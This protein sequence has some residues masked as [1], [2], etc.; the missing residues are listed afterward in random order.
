MNKTETTSSRKRRMVTTRRKSV[1]PPFLGGSL[2][3]ALLL[4]TVQ[5]FSIRS[6]RAHFNGQ[7][8]LHS[9]IER[10]DATSSQ[11]TMTQRDKTSMRA[12]L[13]KTSLPYLNYDIDFGTNESVG[14]NEKETR[15]F[16][17]I[18]D[19]P[20]RVESPSVEESWE[21]LND[22][23]DS[24]S[25]GFS[26]GWS[27]YVPKGVSASFFSTGTSKQST[28]LVLTP[29]RKNIRLG[30]AASAEFLR[31][32][33]QIN[34]KWIDE[35]ILE[36]GGVVFR[37]FG[38]AEYSKD[39]Y[40]NNNK[41]AAIGKEIIRA[42]SS[43]NNKSEGIRKGFDYYMVSNE[44]SRALPLS[45]IGN[46]IDLSNTKG[47]EPLRLSE[48]S[49]Q[50]RVTDWRKIHDDLPAKLRR[51]LEDKNLLYK[52]THVEKIMPPKSAIPFRM[53][54]S[55][56]LNGND[57]TENALPRMPSSWFRLFGS[58]NKKVLQTA[59]QQFINK[60][61][62]RVE[63]S[64][65]ECEAFRRHPQTNEKIWFGLAHRFHWTS[66]PAE[67]LSEFKRNKNP[68]AL[69]RA[70]RE[71]SIGIWKRLRWRNQPFPTSRRQNQELEATT[72]AFGDGIPI[73]WWE[74]HQIRRAI[75]Q[76]TAKYSCK[77]GDIFVVDGLSVGLQ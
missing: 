30:T 75:S 76:N 62:Y 18:L 8:V 7:Q 57:R 24:S 67:L 34:Q 49:T 35:R 40:L 17:S 63:E 28:P 16:A 23:M 53:K 70:V 1:T 44:N 11:V 3:I 5:S 60:M 61:P 48:I 15:A 36:Y 12:R 9:P 37:G 26:L 43:G 72:V 74:M 41:N 46:R 77:P 33:L 42:F 66:L 2:G 13:G 10:N 73:S 56:L 68:L 29:D 4:S 55:A 51:K 50:T 27:L 14:L 25:S 45:S 19:S 58:T 31:S 65:F 71:A 22:V 69:A 47:S 52:R 64:G 21:G 6:N 54:T 38:G 39:N 32:F 20:T 59:Y